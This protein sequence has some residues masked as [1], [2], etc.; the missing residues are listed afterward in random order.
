[1]GYFENGVWNEGWYRPDGKGAFQR[2][3]TQFRDFVSRDGTTHHPAEAHRYRLYVSTACPWATR[4]LILLKSRG[5]EDVID[6]SIVDPKMGPEGWRLKEGLLRDL[7]LKARADY[8]GRVTV[9]VLWDKVEKTIVNNESREVMRMLDTEFEAYA[10]NSD[11]L[12]PVELRDSVDAAIDAMYEPINNGVY[13]AGFAG[14]QEAY[15]EACTS[16][17]DALDQY[18]ALLSGQRYL[19]GNT[20]T[21]ADVCLYTTLVRFDL[22]YYS[23]FKCNIRRIADY[24]HLSGYVR[25]L[26]Q[27]PAFRDSTDLEGIKVHYY[28]SQDHLNPSRIV[29]LGP[30]LDLEAPHDRARLSAH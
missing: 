14:S 27:T 5:L 29:P 23:H 16:L 18:D 13:R 11:S 2:P 4:T 30:T 12:Y 17:F 21:E 28:W 9:P 26:F 1:M 15:E 25:D 7:Y 24:P 8:T 6:V 20:L 19:C 10:K 3:A 22:V